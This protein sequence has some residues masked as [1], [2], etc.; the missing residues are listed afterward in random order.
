M[1]VTKEID[2]LSP[3]FQNKLFQ[4]MQKNHATE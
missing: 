3:D 4:P 2:M 1:F